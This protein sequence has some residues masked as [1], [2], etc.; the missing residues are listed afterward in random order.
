[1]TIIQKRKYIILF[2][3]IKKIYQTKES[4]KNIKPQKN[5]TMA[6]HGAYK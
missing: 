2:S 1:M 6:K 5:N 3:S 4:Q